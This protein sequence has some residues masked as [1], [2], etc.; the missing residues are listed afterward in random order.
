V[1]TTLALLLVCGLAVG[2]FSMSRRGLGATSRDGRLRLVSR[3]TLG[4]HQQLHL[5]QADARLLLIGTGQSGTPTLL[6][7]LDPRLDPDARVRAAHADAAPNT[8]MRARDA[9]ASD[10]NANPT[11]PAGQ[12]ATTLPLFGEPRT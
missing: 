4:T 3:L 10:A 1:L 12:D 8:G 11:A 6:T 7:E 2:L 5:V 9:A